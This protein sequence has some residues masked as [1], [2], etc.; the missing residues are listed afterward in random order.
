MSLSLHNK[1]N[2]KRKICTSEVA[3]V[4][5][6]IGKKMFLRRG[7]LWKPTTNYRNSRIICASTYRSLAHIPKNQ[8]ITYSYSHLKTNK[9]SIQYISGP[10]IC[11]CL[12]HSNCKIRLVVQKLERMGSDGPRKEGTRG[13]L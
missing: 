12:A 9:S 5:K 3:T 10:P 4:S 8:K 6:F 7:D 1:T 11:Q 13:E 2:Y